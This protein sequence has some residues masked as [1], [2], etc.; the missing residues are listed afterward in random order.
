MKA[1]RPKAVAERLGIAR[2]T[3]FQWVQ[4]GKFPKPTKLSTK[5]SVWDETAVEDWL[6]AKKEV[7]DGSSNVA[8]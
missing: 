5:V 7:Q 1:L 8:A 2:V 6:N 3:L 4:K